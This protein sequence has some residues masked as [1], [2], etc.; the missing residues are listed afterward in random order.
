MM[1]LYQS[2]KRILRKQDDDRWPSWIY[3]FLSCGT[4][5]WVIPLT[6]LTLGREI[7]CWSPDAIL[8][9]KKA[10]IE[11]DSDS[12]VLNSRHLQAT[13]LKKISFL[14]LSSMSSPF[15]SNAYGLFV[16]LTFDLW[17]W[18]FAWYDDG[19]IVKKVWQTDGRSEPFI[20]LLGRREKSLLYQGMWI[21]LFFR[22]YQNIKDI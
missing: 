15:L 8:N 22:V 2:E 17:P 13:F 7:F 16:T 12:S 20:Q 10:F 19:N 3:G 21:L 4:E 11:N 5:T 18:P 1:I 14:E 6:S 9:Y